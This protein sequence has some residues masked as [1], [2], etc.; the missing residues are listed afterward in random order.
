MTVAPGPTLETAR[1]NLRPTAAEDLDGWAELMGD[2][3]AA[4]YI[5]GQQNRDASWRGL[6]TMAG[7]WAL[8]GFGMFSLIEKSSGD[9][10]GRIGPWRPEG[11]P[12]TEVG[13]SLVRRAWGKGYAIEAATATIDW[14]FDHLGWDDVIHC[15]H[16][17]NAA[18]QAVARR[19]G[20]TNR[21]PQPLPA[22]FSHLP[23]EVWG[24]G[25]AQ[26]KARVR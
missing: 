18:S 3:E 25:K 13:W 6:A 23:N 14:A 16:P 7:S 1:L 5:G 19:L 2:A 20:S 12:G 9:W 21:G 8:N 22:P 17:E 24:Q 10:L 4:R 11:W 15:I 26:W